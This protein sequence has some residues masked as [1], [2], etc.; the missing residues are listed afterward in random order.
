MVQVDAGRSFCAS[1]GV[2]IGVRFLLGPWSSIAFRMLSSKLEFRW[3]LFCES[4]IS[5][6]RLFFKLNEDSFV[7]SYFSI[8]GTK[9][10]TGKLLGTKA[11]GTAEHVHTDTHRER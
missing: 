5:P 11:T 8:C 10:W 7:A 1:D 4:S 3:L 9:K 6:T 2:N